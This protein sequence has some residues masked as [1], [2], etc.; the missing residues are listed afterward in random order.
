MST[1]NSADT[2]SEAHTGTSLALYDDRQQVVLRTAIEL[3]SVASTGVETRR[4]REQLKNKQKIIQ[5]FFDWVNKNPGDVEPTDVRAWCE[6]MEDEG[7]SPATVYA[8]VAY[9]SSFYRWAMSQPA[10]G[11]HLRQNPAL[12]ARPKRVRPYQTEATKAWTDEE[13]RA[14]TGVIRQ[15]AA[16]GDLVAKRDLTLFLLGLW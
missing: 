12:L 8:R 1:P 9:L 7:K 14:L 15:K 11:A 16:S 5:S 2:D 4:R 13:L 10:V 6:R 3:W